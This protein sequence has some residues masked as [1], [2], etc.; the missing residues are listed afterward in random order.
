MTDSIRGKVAAIIDDTTLVLN[1]GS[2]QGVC[3]GMVF[4]IVS[5]HQEIVDPDTGESLGS[6]EVP[7]ARVVVTHLQERLCT[8]RS[9]LRQEVEVPGTLSTM[10]VRHSFGLFG[11]RHDDR[12][13]LDVRRTGLAGRPQLEPIQVGDQA[14][15]VGVQEQVETAPAGTDATSALDLPSQTYTASAPAGAAPQPSPG[16]GASSEPDGES[17]DQPD[18]G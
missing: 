8:V 18:A 14:R 17:K 15:S 2:T 9:P 5:E 6:W 1:V 12:H 13:S 11:D 3:E 10:M 7:K 4:A 16:S